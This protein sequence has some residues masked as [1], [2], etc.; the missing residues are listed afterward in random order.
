MGTEVKMTKLPWCDICEQHSRTVL[1]EYDAKTAAGPWAYMCQ[2]C[3]SMF[4][5][6]PGKLGTGMGQRLVLRDKGGA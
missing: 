1:A 3:W 2:L 6:Y 4:S 5:A